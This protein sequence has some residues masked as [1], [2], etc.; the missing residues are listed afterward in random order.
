MDRRHLLASL[1]AP[2]L[3]QSA[4][5]RTLRFIPIA[6]LGPIDPIITTTY[7]TRNH[8]YLV[9][10]TLYGLDA[11]YRPQ[12]QMAAGHSVEQEGRLV[13]IALRDGL[14]FHDGTPVR[15]RDAVASIRRWGAR[16]GLGQTLMATTDEL[17][18]PDDTTILFRLKRPFPLLFDALAKTS[19]P[20]CFIMPERLAE[21]DPATPIRE[22][23]GSGPYR[24]LADERISGARVAYARFDGYRPR[25]DGTPSGT[26]GPKRAWFDRVEWQVIPDASTA[27]A[28]AGPGGV[29]HEAERGGPAAP[30]DASAGAGDGCGRVAAGAVVPARA[31]VGVRHE[32]CAVGA[33]RRRRR[34]GALR[35]GTRLP[36]RERA[37]PD[38]H[39]RV[40][41]APDTERQREREGH[42]RAHR[43]PVVASAVAG[44]ACP[45][46]QVVAV[47]VE[48]VGRV[49]RSVPL[50]GP[51]GSIVSPDW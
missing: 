48:S 46:V 29:D 15:A 20:V 45:R 17:S 43:N 8:A 9:W 41:G 31:G 5:S 30:V 18:A 47:C 39:G 1:A 21:T 28:V 13:R 16:D 12:P 23:I 51:V 49:T 4:R 42:Q 40:L 3:A 2:A 38:P 37:R 35:V 6:D 50:V 10:D 11:E 14:M 26:A 25:E 19:P 7:I 36:R 27:A 33:T 44:S 32:R 34:S 22:A 24:F